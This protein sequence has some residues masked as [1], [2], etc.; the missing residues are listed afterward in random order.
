MT[1]TA[2]KLAAGWA[3]LYGTV[4]LIWT[5]TGRGFPYGPGQRNMQT[6]PLR[7]LDPSVGAPLFAGVLLLTAVV[8]LFMSGRPAAS[9]PLRTTLL[10]Y[11]GL[12]AAALLVV[13]P[14]TRLL[15]VA[16][17]LPMLIV[18]F[19][20]GW[21]PVDYSTVFTWTLANQAFAVA[22]GLLLVRAALRWHFAV[23]G[24]CEDCGRDR[25]TAGWTSRESAARWGRWAVGVAAVIPVSYAVVRL[26]W[27]AGIPLGISR[28]FL[29]EMQET[30]LVW[31]GF[32][33][34]SF[35]VAGS[36]LTLGLVQRWGETFPRWMVGP[37]G[38]RV[39]IKLATVPAT[40]VTIFVMSASVAFY[41]E[42]GFLAE[43]AEDGLVVAPMLAWPFWSLALG[44]ATLAY[45]LRRRPACAACGRGD[46]APVL[47]P[48]Q[49]AGAY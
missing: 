14:D 29:R 1:N 16:G 31:A 25:R 26:A 48:R 2:Q 35:A 44:A 23:T 30:G 40:L 37:A 6:S 33:L 7:A 38:R 5:V 11:V 15:T 20:F 17:Y 36:I 24:A 8:L 3:A 47:V 10:A 46:P 19:P 13:L 49:E 18:G 34:A 45:Y 9:R 21:P 39:P 41:A 22:G 32:G 28:E 12:V 42:P 27:V 43:V 4:A